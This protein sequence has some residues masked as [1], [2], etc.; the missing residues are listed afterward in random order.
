M[1][2]NKK[3]PLPGLLSGSGIAEFELSK[4]HSA[5]KYP[6][7]NSNQKG[8]REKCGVTKYTN[9][10][11]QNELHIH[12]FLFRKAFFDSKRRHFTTIM[13]RHS[14]KRVNLQGRN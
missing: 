2:N 12:V 1:M 10:H 14:S 7:I 9:A 6:F 13:I 3:A 4:P 5:P 8:E 11:K